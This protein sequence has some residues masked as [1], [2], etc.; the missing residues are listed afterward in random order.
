MD[1]G[2]VLQNVLRALLSLYHKLVFA[3]SIN[4][5]LIFAGKARILPL[6]ALLR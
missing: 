3:R 5:S 4:P 6:G 1:Q 2:P